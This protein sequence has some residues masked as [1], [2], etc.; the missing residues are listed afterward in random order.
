M[1]ALGGQGTFPIC[2][3]FEAHASKPVIHHLNRYSSENEPTSITDA[4]SLN[5]PPRA[6]WLV[7]AAPV[8]QRCEW[9]G[10]EPIRFYLRGEP[11]WSAGPDP[12]SFSCRKLRTCFHAS[13]VAFGSYSIWCLR[14]SRGALGKLNPCVAPG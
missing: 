11:A 8:S 6:A 5:S 12:S 9:I 4:L 14:Y 3:A 13:A 7:A 2:P 1:A 10:F